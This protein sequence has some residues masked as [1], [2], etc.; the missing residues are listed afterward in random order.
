MAEV[1]PGNGRMGGAE[2]GSVYQQARL[3]ESVVAYLADYYVDPLDESA[4]YDMAIDG[5]LK[6]VGDPYTTFLRP[7]DFQQLTLSTTGNYGGLGIRI[8][9]SDGWITV[10]APLPDTPAERLGIQAGDRIVEVDGT[11]T[12]GWPVVIGFVLLYR[13]VKKER[14]LTA[15]INQVEQSLQQPEP[16]QTP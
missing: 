1:G 2:A 12:R 11:S 16:N 13:L 5:L 6:E 9:V 14:N 4:I 3:F 10:V 15:Q 7:E 8:E